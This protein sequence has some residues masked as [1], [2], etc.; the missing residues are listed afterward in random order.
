MI[1]SVLLLLP[2][3]IGLTWSWSESRRAR[4]EDVRGDAAALAAAS[5]ASFDQFLR[6][7]DSIAAVLARHP[8]VIALNRP[9]CDRLF[10]EILREQPLLLNILLTA[11]DETI[12]GSALPTANVRPRQPMPHI[13]QVI[14]TG[15][16][17]TSEL[18]VGPLTHKPTVI[19]GYPVRSGLGTV[20]GV[21]A[22]GLDLSQ[23]QSTFVGASIPDGAVITLTTPT[24]LVLARSREG[25][26][27]IGTTIE[28][29]RVPGQSSS[30][31]QM[32]P[33]GVER[34]VESAGV[35]RGPWLMSAGIPARVVAA[36]L[37][38][39][40]RPTIVVTTA[41]AL[42]W[43]LVTF[44]M[45]RDLSRQI[46]Q[47]CDAARRVA[48]GDS[49][50]VTADGS[51]SKDL[52][53]LQASLV[54]IAEN[55]RQTRAEL[56]RQIEQER[57]TREV[58]ETSQRHLVRQERLAAVGLLL[59]GVAHELNNPLQAI[60]GGAELLERRTDLSA[61]AQEE[62][63]LVST[64]SQRA[65]EIIRNL[66]RFGN[67]RPAL[68]SAIDLRDVV[69]EV[70]QLRHTDLEAA[71]ITCDVQTNSS[72]KVFASFTEI[73]QV[74]L[75]FVINAQQSIHSARVTNGVIII[76]SSDTEN[77]VR[78]EVIDNGPGVPPQ[79]E[80]QLFQPFF[81]TKPVGEGTGLGLSVSHGIIDVSGGR[82][83]YRR[84]DAG[85]AT[86]YFELPRV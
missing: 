3:V 6:G 80:A 44:W 50:Q 84:N 9:E 17:V 22:F 65:A 67:Q 14:S 73:E 30:S 64:Q 81:T 12:K 74:V 36:R 49:P 78:L 11:P 7:L 83:G 37:W 86:F 4:T 57:E 62:V 24:G 39:F 25:D 85:G 45:T 21:L 41:V 53:P 29:S 51:L 75:N 66:S 34:F 60:M 23:L 15:R 72:G 63:A 56:A 35:G 61:E 40:G 48:R 59:A 77:C 5:A 31:P 13:P 8:S 32:D 2:L 54:T 19:L 68:P 1:S 46:Q 20:V 70:V 18:S 38:P 76:R 27:Y 33:G 58:L 71:G 79:E 55:L 16:P 69:A 42:V 26:R 28:T 43:L 82:I 52:A 47:L 10:A